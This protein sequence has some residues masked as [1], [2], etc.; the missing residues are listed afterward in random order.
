MV[1]TEIA[2]IFR[3]ISQILEIKGENVFRIRA[4]QRAAENIEGESEDL[5][6]LAK[7]GRLR[8]IPGIGIDLSERIKEF[9]ASGKI[10]FFAELQKSIP[11]GLLEILD[12]PSV[13]P[14]KAKLLFE[15]LKIKNIAG[16]EKAIRQN[17]LSGVFGIKQKTVENILKGIEISKLGKERLTLAQAAEIGDA[18]V[19]ALKTLAEVKKIS[20]AGSLRRQKE[21]VRDIDILV[22]SRHPRK[23]MDAFVSL[24]QAKN[25]QAKGQTKASLRTSEDVQVDC[26][27]VED[28][29]FGA[30]QMYFTG[31]K[32]FNIK[33]RQLAL[34][35][36]LKVNEYGIFRGEKFLCGRSEEEIFKFFGMEFIPPEL[37]ENNGEIELARINQLPHLIEL[38]DLK[39][40]PHTHSIWSDGKNSIE[41]LA[42]ACIKRD[43]S[44]VAVTD[45]SQ[46]LKV[47]NGLT[48]SGLKKKKAEIQRLNGKFKNFTV[49]YAAEVDIDAKGKLDYPDEV[50]AEFDLV[51]AAIHSG[52]K[53]SGEQ[54]TRRIVKACENKFCHIIAHPTGRL[55]GEREAYDF[56]FAQIL[57]AARDTNTHLEINSFPRRLDL[58]DSHARQAKEAG[59]KMVIS[60]DAHRVEQLEAM[61]F[62][63][64]V[65]RRGWLE[66]KDVMNTLPLKGLLKAIKK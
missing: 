34:K 36:G 30:A 9:L 20:L 60:T 62:G 46:G 40:D 54:I 31:S 12:I 65:A 66:A 15:K 64:A 49:L 61:K 18:F 28:K 26:R 6:K 43:Y 16:L 14:K 5:E 42:D 19:S 50:L 59:V 56:D 4:Y 29:S 38:K 39:G 58:N 21:T 23:V 41:D 10:K 53:Q 37:R 44:Y 7:E 45:H 1:N 57:E 55:W 8:E 32:E 52:F 33:M 63:V 25:I 3:Q 48:L 11:Q 17:K 13:G 2:K 27:V 47:A 22:V 51:V 35:K 24:P